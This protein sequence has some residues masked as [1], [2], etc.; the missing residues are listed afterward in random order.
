MVNELSST[1]TRAA[2]LTARVIKNE[3]TVRRWRTDLIT[4]GGS[5]TEDKYGQYQRTEVLWGNE[6]LNKKASKYVRAN[7][8]VKGTPN[9]T[10][11]EFCNRVNKP[12]LPNSI[13]RAR[14]FST[15][16]S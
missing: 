3:K 12:L 11:M 16:L 10:S 6:E 15:N 2:E 4:N 14:I 9:M 1:E 8:A 7:A 5:F 13:F